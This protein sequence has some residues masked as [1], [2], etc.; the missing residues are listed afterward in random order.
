MDAHVDKNVHANIDV[1]D[2]DVWLS[3][4]VC[5]GVADA[6]RVEE[7]HIARITDGQLRILYRE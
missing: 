7:A 6:W 4:C 2:M 1:D 3:V 5:G